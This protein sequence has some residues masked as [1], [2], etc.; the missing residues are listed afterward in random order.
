MQLDIKETTKACRVVLRIIYSDF[1]HG[2]SKR[3][4]KGTFWRQEEARNALP[5]IPDPEG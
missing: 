2:H 4:I 5:W 3:T 1:K